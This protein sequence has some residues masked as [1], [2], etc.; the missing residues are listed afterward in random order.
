GLIVGFVP[1]MGALHAGHRQL[2]ETAR[3]ECG[4]VVVSIFVNPLQFDRP[5]DLARYPRSLDADQALCSSAGVDVIFVPTVEELY[6][7]EQKA[8]V[9]VPDLTRNLCGEFRPGHFRG[10]A[11]VVLKLFGIVQPDRA[12]FGQKDAQQ[13]AVIQRMVADLNVPVEI[14][15]VPT[16][17]EPDGLALSSRIKHLSAAERQI[18]PALYR[19]LVL[20]SGRIASGERSVHAVREKALQFLRRHPELKI[21]YLEFVDPS[22]LEPLQELSGRVLIATAAWLGQTRLIDNVISDSK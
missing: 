15:P 17:R 6:P 9:D 16:V 13:L 5:D 18:A 12:Y 7:R 3:R 4:F 22:T 11:T 21:E 14:V 1:T 20:A 19:A 2:M 10:V 8:F